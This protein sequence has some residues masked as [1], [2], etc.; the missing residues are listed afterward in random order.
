[1][2]KFPSRA[3]AIFREN[4]GDGFGAG[5]RTKNGKKRSSKITSDSQVNY[6]EIKQDDRRS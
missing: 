6:F 1:M 2:A 4:S 3:A 5:S